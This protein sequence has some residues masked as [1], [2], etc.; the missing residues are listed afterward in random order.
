MKKVEQWLA[1]QPRTIRTKR[2]LTNIEIEE[3]KRKLENINNILYQEIEII[4]HIVQ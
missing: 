4:L 3:I 1:D 2:W